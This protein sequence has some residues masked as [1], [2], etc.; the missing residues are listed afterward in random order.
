MVA[1]KTN[2]KLSLNWKKT[3][4]SFKILPGKEVDVPEDVVEYL[5]TNYPDMSIEYAN[6]IKQHLSTS[7]PIVTSNKND[8]RKKINPELV[9]DD[10][11][12]DLKDN[13]LNDLVQPIENQENIDVKPIIEAALE[14]GIITQKGVWYTYQGNSIAKGIKKLKSNLEDNAILRNEIR[15][16]L[17]G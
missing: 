9:T 7:I 16:Q 8:K 11:A 5:K 2:M 15:S 12:N 4:Q 1:I 13:I 6:E 10:F 14:K 3:N 17:N